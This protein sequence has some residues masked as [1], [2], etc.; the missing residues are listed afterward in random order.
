MNRKMTVIISMLVGALSAFHSLDA[1]H[2]IVVEDIPGAPKSRNAV[3]WGTSDVVVDGFGITA[4]LRGE[5]ANLG[6]HE[7]VLGVVGLGFDR[8]INSD[9]RNSEALVFS[10]PDETPNGK[11]IGLSAMMFG[12]VNTGGSNDVIIISGFSDDPQADR[13]SVV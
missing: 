13:K 1:A 6:G 11:F 9:G 8:S 4:V 5:P 3:D 12:S 10:I 7:A 2:R